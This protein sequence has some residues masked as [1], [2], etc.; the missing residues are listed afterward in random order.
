MILSM[1]E[2]GC[3]GCI[4]F[5]PTVGAASQLRRSITN[6]HLTTGSDAPDGLIICRKIGI[7]VRGGA[8]DYSYHPFLWKTGPN[9]EARSPLL[10][11]RLR[12]QTGTADMEQR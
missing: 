12:M 6:Q 8:V 5:L 7:Q 3:G 4:K 11:L 10:F 2:V 1:R 9:G